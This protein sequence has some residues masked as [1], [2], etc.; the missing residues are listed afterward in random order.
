MSV[1][2]PELI[3]SLSI[4][5]E[6]IK[7]PKSER[8]YVWGLYH[9]INVLAKN[10]TR[11]D[12]LFKNFCTEVANHAKKLGCEHRVSY[13]DEAG[14]VEVL[15]A[16]SFSGITTSEQLE[17]YPCYDCREFLYAKARMVVVSED[18]IKIVSGVC[19]ESLPDKK[20]SRPKFCGF[21]V[22][23]NVTKKIV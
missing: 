15:S 13:L 14:W 12:E 20:C 6:V 11:N 3:H 9:R 5:D 18:T 7:K 19:S 21:S 23:A 10:E 8:F 17:H 22:V 2:H 4:I 16:C 1:T